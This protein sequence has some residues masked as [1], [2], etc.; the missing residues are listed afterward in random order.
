MIEFFSTNGIALLIAVPL[1]SAFLT[2]LF[3]K[4]NRFLRN[5]YI[6]FS[7]IVTVTIGFFVSY[8]IFVS[9]TLV[10]TLGA[11]EPGLTMPS[12]LRVPVRIVLVADAFSA[13]MILSSSI[14]FFV[15]TIYSFG[16][17]R[18]GFGKYFSLFFIMA[19]SV[20]GI[21]CTG[22]LFNLFVFIEILSIS[23]T[24]LIAF[25][26]EKPLSLISAYNYLIV[27]AVASLMILFGI[28]ILYGQYGMLNIAAVS[29]AIKFSFVD[30]FAMVLLIAGLAMKCGSVPMHFWV[31]DAYGRAPSAVTAFLVVSSQASLYALFRVSFMLFAG[32]SLIQLVALAIITFGLLSMFIGVTMALVQ[33]DIKRLM[34][35]HAVSQTGYMLLGVGVGLFS[36]NTTFYSHGL[37]AMEGGIFH[38]INHAL[39]KGL[40]FLTAGA[41]I[42]ATK[43]R[44]LNKIGGIARKMPFTT[45]FFII[46]AAAIAGLPPTNG[47]ASKFLIYESVFVFNP[48]L[49]IIAVIVSMLTLISFVKI[50]CSA[51]LGPEREEL[52]NIKEV[53]KPMLVA[54]SLLALCI[55][56]FG[57]FPDSV[58]KA[59]IEPA[60]KALLSQGAYLEAVF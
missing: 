59:I 5:L 19:A 48:L 32:F 17:I 10:Y 42:Y 23:S 18:K 1:L 21:L 29:R 46:G 50:F 30:V 36:I 49:S 53:P 12:G 3:E 31:P 35:Y 2:P 44:D 47:F 4:I 58:L 13:F 41:I 52:K 6:I 43:E 27:S 56:S 22:D 25:R 20:F 33:K 40:L 11:T 24:G 7:V 45:I 37:L 9:G 54:M 38:I 57:L 8:T 39:Y 34:A 26:K 51:F 28:G 55:I 60:A 15:S 16:S 14:I